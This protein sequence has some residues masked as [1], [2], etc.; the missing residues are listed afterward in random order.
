MSGRRSHARFAVANPWSGDIR[1]L[2]D[3]VVDRTERDELLA[4]SN[5]PAVIGE[6]L[7]LDLIGDGQN[8]AI[9][10]RVIDSRPVIIDGTVR[11]RI[12]LALLEAEREEPPTD[13]TVADRPA[14]EGLNERGGEVGDD[15]C[16]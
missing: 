8:V 10:V 1:I 4:V 6:V 13:P 3:V 9:K 15:G 7:S 16:S 14:V 5:A 11:H 12:R 2:R